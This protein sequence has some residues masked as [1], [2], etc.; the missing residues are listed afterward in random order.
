MAG[1]KK[2]FFKCGSVAGSTILNPF[3]ALPVPYP[4]RYFYLSS[5]QARSNEPEGSRSN[6]CRMNPHCNF[7]SAFSQKCLAW[8]QKHLKI[9][10]I[11]QTVKDVAPDK[12]LHMWQASY[13]GFSYRS[14]RSSLQNVREVSGKIKMMLPLWFSRPVLTGSHTYPKQP[15]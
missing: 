2:R 6:P 15:K 12:A 3:Q 5:A 4:S 11:R 8:N 7:S 13:C 9:A 14:L 10:P 1:K